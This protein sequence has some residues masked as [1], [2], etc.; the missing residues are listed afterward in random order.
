[1]SEPTF[2]AC[3]RC[4]EPFPMS[5][6]QKRL[7]IGRT[8]SCNRC[9]KPFSITEE[10]PDPVPAKAMRG[11][12]AVPQSLMSGPSS[13][14]PASANSLDAL[15]NAN[16]NAAVAAGAPPTAGA[17]GA[18]PVNVA[19]PGE[20]LTAARMALLIAVVVVAMGFLLYLAISPSVHR[21]REAARR[22]SC[23][24]NLM[25]IGLALQRYTGN[26]GGRYPDALDVLVLDGSL[27]AEL[28]VCPSSKD[29]LVPGASPGEQVANLA[30]GGHDS[31]VYVAKD[32]R[33]SPGKRVVAFEPLSHHENEGVNVLYTDGSVQFL[34][35]SAALMAIPQLTA[36]TTNPAATTLP[37]TSGP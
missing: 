33:L 29:T 22:A 5:V 25:Q 18:A 6:M 15:A 13:S 10:T 11:N 3:P 19:R 1:M 28:L 36:P 23:A 2:I 17:P 14:T 16:A 9:T 24:S 34:T 7:F 4:G 8:L 27:P 32:T 30:K 26:N 37:A 31:Y 12:S 20:G 21:A 35:R